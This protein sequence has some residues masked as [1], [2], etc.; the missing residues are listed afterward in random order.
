MKLSIGLTIFKQQLEHPLKIEFY[1][2]VSVDCSESS[3]NMTIFLLL[4]SL[5]T[6]VQRSIATT[7]PPLHPLS[8]TEIPSSDCRSPFDYYVVLSRCSQHCMHFKAL[9]ILL[10]R[11]REEDAEGYPVSSLL[12]QRQLLL[13]S[14]ERAMVPPWFSVLVI[15]TRTAP[16]CC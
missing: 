6:K 15:P 16:S 5:T 8:V 4:F 7:S 9:S 11:R 1:C 3:N 14:F 2:L 10:V 13:P 12:V